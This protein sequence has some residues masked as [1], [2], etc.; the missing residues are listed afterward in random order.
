MRT[1][2]PFFS[3]RIMLLNSCAVCICP[4]VR[5]VSSTLLPS[6]L[7][8]G[9]S[10]FSLVIVFLMSTGVMP[11]AAIFTGSSHMRME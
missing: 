9:N 6:M 5:R 2:L 3:F 1:M 4:I 11:Y 10:T 7:P 8:D